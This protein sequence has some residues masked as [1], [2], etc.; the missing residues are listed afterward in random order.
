MTRVCI[1]VRTCVCV[2][3]REDNV[4][5]LQRRSQRGDSP[6]FG[7]KIDLCNKG[8]IFYYQGVVEG[9]LTHV[10]ERISNRFLN[11]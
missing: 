3:I 6:F 2:K 10:S 8:S 4:F 1:C 5:D 11:I 9:I 7:L